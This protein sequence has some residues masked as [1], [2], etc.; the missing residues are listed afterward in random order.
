MPYDGP[1]T[2]SRKRKNDNEAAPLQHKMPKQDRIWSFLQGQRLNKNEVHNLLLIA[3]SGDSVIEDHE[4]AL[5]AA[6]DYVAQDPDFTQVK[7]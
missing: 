3:N 4:L 6:L 5:Q 1:L 2:R 7:G